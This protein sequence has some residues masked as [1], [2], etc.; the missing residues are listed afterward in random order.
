M[1]MAHKSKFKR[2]VSFLRKIRTLPRVA[3]ILFVLM[4]PAVFLSA[5]SWLPEELDV[6]NYLDDLDFTGYL[7]GDD[8]DNS[9]DLILDNSNVYES[10]DDLWINE[11]EEFPILTSSDTVS[12]RSF[13]PE[14]LAQVEEGLIAVR[15]NSRHTEETLRSRYLE[16]DF[17]DVDDVGDL[18]SEILAGQQRL[19]DVN[20]NSPSDDLINSDISFNDEI[21]T[22]KN[23]NRS[24]NIRNSQQSNVYIESDSI[25]LGLGEEIDVFRDNFNKRFFESGGSIVSDK[26]DLELTS[27]S[28]QDS[29]WTDSQMQNEVSGL[30]EEFS[31]ARVSFLAATINFGTGSSGLSGEDHKTLKEVSKLC[32]DFGGTIKVIG[33]ASS[34]TRDLEIDDR[35]IV[36]FNISVD[37]ANVVAKI[38]MRHGV[39]AD[40]LEVIAM[41]D[42][43]P[44]AHEYMPSGERENQR[45]EIYIEY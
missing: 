33:H 18:D 14:E 19:A 44:V 45:T 4:T 16:D 15:D 5:C 13:D 2:G 31:G 34:R 41:A 28:Q 9:S 43:E 11:D 30:K 26:I 12:R 20:S 25:H 27:N 6:T 40:K 32:L 37:R 8:E 35:K 22:S 29:E 7:W 1:E 10:E 36:N 39:P 24:E 3:V 23:F 17:I 21:N 38:L 42:K